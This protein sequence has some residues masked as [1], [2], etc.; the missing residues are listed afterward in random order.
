MMELNEVR[1]E[2][3]DGRLDMMES[4]V[5]RIQSVRVLVS[6]GFYIRVGVSGDVTWNSFLTVLT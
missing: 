1:P 5:V 3:E 6:A 2:K 4:N